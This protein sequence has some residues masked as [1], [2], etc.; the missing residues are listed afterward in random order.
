MY[1]TSTIDWAIPATNA[2]PIWSGVATETATTTKASPITRFPPSSIV[3]DPAASDA[4]SRE[5]RSEHCPDA[6]RGEDQAQDGRRVPEVAGDV[7]GECGDQRCQQ[8]R[9]RP[10]EQD[11][12]PQVGSAAMKSIPSRISVKSRRRG[13]STGARRSRR[14][15][16]RPSADSANDSASIARV[17]P[18]P[19]V[20]AR[21]PAMAG[22]MM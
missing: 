13:R 16:R 10:P 21:T 4:A 18:G 11:D 17:G 9:G 6:V 7:D 15:N 3:G 1:V 20:A 2:A 5:E 12:R 19:I 22:P 8:D 14:T